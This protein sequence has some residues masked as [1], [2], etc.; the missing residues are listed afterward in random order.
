MF[1]TPLY[2][3]MKT[4]MGGSKAPRVPR[5]LNCMKMSSWFHAQVPFTNRTPAVLLVARDADLVILAQSL[6]NMKN[7]LAD[8]EL[9]KQ[10]CIQL[11]TEQL[12]IGTSDGHNGGLHQVR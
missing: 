12:L 10:A 4:H 2:H 9:Y 8:R 5:P 7:V 6:L 11:L 1:H 3:A